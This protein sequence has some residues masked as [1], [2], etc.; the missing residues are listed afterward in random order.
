MRHANE[1]KMD[2]LHQLATGAGISPASMTYTMSVKDFLMHAHEM[3]R[4]ELGKDIS[5]LNVGT[6]SEV[7]LNIFLNNPSQAVTGPDSKVWSLCDLLRVHHGYPV[8]SGTDFAAELAGRLFKANRLFVDQIKM[9]N[10]WNDVSITITAKPKDRYFLVINPSYDSYLYGFRSKESNSSLTDLIKLWDEEMQPIEVWR[11]DALEISYADYLALLQIGTGEWQ[12]HKKVAL[13]IKEKYLNGRDYRYYLDINPNSGQYRKVYS[14]SPLQ[15]ITDTYIEAFD[16]VHGL[17]TLQ[18]DRNYPLNM[19]YCELSSEE[20]DLLSNVAMNGGVDC[21][22]YIK[23]SDKIIHDRLPVYQNLS[24]RDIF[25]MTDSFTFWHSL[26]V[27]EDPSLV[28][29]GFLAYLL[30]N[31]QGVPVESVLNRIASN[32]TDYD[33]LCAFLKEWTLVQQGER[34][35]K[36]TSEQTATLKSLLQVLCELINYCDSDDSFHNWLIDKGMFTR[37]LDELLNDLADE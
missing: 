33:G 34:V 21:E 15:K 22:S 24:R 10:D 30:A 31:G 5:Q 29:E 36:F 25:E 23:A 11:R 7:E 2:L 13:A 20:Y 16:E 17:I 18:R 27:G 3:L 35:H 6:G 37:S 12:E 14:V 8:F 26:H 4:D 28:Q 19:D 32:T 1:L 9:M